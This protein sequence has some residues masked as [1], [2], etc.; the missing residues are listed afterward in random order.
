MLFKQFIKPSVCRLFRQI[1]IASFINV[2]FGI[3]IMKYECENFIV[4]SGRF[5]VNT[6]IFKKLGIVID[7]NVGKNVYENVNQ[8]LITHGH[9]DHFGDAFMLKN[10]AKILAPR[11]ELPFVENPEINWRGMYSW[12]KLPEKVVTPYFLGR[13][14][15][16]DYFSDEMEISIKMPG[17]TPGH[18]AYL[19]DSIFVV[20]DAIHSPKCWEK[21]GILYYV[22]PRL[23]AESINAV[24]DLD[25]DVLVLGHCDIIDNKKEGIKIMKYNLK[26]LEKVDREIYEF[27]KEREEVAECEIFSHFAKKYNFKGIRANLV[28]MPPIRGHLSDL[29]ERGALD[30]FEK[31]GIIMFRVKSHYKSILN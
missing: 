24:K 2:G 29:C 7:P 8:V 4:Y 28:I 16:V 22:D 27:V 19:I 3:R 18:T 10:K 12:A 23:M 25:W 26:M 21:F 5:E 13:G 14:V 6:T 31:D 15:K 11:S 30:M 20:G 17:H 9:A 1:T